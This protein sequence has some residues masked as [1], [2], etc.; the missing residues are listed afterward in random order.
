MQHYK[1]PYHTDMELLK[2]STENL[3][4]AV[5][6][7]EEVGVLGGE[8]FLRKELPEILTLLSDNKKVKRVKVITNGTILPSQPVLDAL[9]HKKI[10]VSISRYPNVDFERI[11]NALEKNGI[12]YFLN[13]YESWSDYGDLSLKPE[14]NGNIEKIY[15][16]CTSA[17][18]KTVLNG[19]LFT[20]PRSSQGND[21][22]IIPAR[23][24]EFVNLSGQSRDNLRKSIKRFYN[25]SY[26]SACNYCNAP[27]NRPE[28]E[29]AKQTP[30]KS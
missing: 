20:C 8:P 2:Q 11:I 1:K 5:D 25:K 12:R 3:L 24:D 6:A 28:I 7:I 9:K 15:S 18:C 19:Q 10:Y 26:I 27:W 14:N 29:C 17:E 16:S 13:C 23:D 21:L 22:G 4:S 30:R